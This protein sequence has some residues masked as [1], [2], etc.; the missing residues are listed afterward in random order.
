MIG[1]FDSG[2]GGLTV[3]REIIKQLP[4][5]SVVYFGDTARTPYGTKGTKAIQNFSVNNAKFLESVGADVIVIAC[6]TAS[7]VALKEVKQAVKVPVLDVVTPAVDEVVARERQKVGVIGTSATV[8]SQVYERLINKIKP[9][10]KVFQQACPL[11]VPIV[12]EG[13]ENRPET[14]IIARRYLNRLKLRNIDTLVLGCTHYPFLRRHIQSE[15]GSNV[16]LIDP[17]QATVA[18]LRR[19]LVAEPGISQPAKKEPKYRF[20]VS[21]VSVNF[22]RSAR[23]WLKRPVKLELANL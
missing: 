12:E 22:E 18:E 13:S 4:D 1:V 14:K 17:A 15:V 23:R 8:R 3:V 16:K 2:L 21:D 7:A 11:F 20:F 10:I 9:K 6:N 19:F 5:Q